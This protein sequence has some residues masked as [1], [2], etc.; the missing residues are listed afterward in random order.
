MVITGG[1]DNLPGIVE[2]EQ[3]VMRMPI[4]LGKPIMLPGVSEK[5]DDPAYATGVGLLL[6]KLRNQDTVGPKSGRNK[7]FGLLNKVIHLLDKR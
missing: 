6:W 4:R 1:G 7:L 5:L 2:R 3:K